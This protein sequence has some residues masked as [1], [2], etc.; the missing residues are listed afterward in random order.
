[1]LFT[2]SIHLQPADESIHEILPLAVI[3]KRNRFIDK[4]T[5]LDPATSATDR[6]GPYTNAS[7]AGAEQLPT[8]Q[9]SR[10]AG[11]AARHIE[12]CQ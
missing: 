4:R 12:R 7:Q 6:H 2:V 5:R 8:V 11:T 9:Y 3:V 10:R 1:V